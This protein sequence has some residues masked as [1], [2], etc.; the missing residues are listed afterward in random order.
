[1]IKECTK[2]VENNNHYLQ[3]W[4]KNM[5]DVEPYLTLSPVQHN[6]QKSFYFF[7]IPNSQFFLN[8]K[9]LFKELLLTHCT[10]H[11][12]IHLQKFHLCSKCYMVKPSNW[13]FADIVDICSCISWR[14][15][16]VA[17]SLFNLKT[18]LLLLCV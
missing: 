2:V 10:N 13:A 8:P 16:I 9:S 11:F 3:F 1:M 12:S 14:P 18:G 4:S 17:S 6:N 7:F 15:Y 5:L